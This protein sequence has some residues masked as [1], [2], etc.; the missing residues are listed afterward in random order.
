[1]YDLIIIGGGP[2]GYTAALESVK[3]NKKVLIIEK[4]D[5]GGVCLNRGCIPTKSL[6]NSGKL[7]KKSKASSE[8]G[9]DYSDISFNFKNAV[10]WKDKSVEELR[11]SL[12]NL[13]KQRGIDVIKGLASVINRNEVKVHDVIYKT[14]FILIATGSKPIIPKI[15]G[16]D[17]EYVL[18]SN[19]ILDLKEKPKSITI[20]GGGVIGV[21]FASFFNSI[22]VK[23]NLIELQKSILPTMDIRLGKVLKK[24]LKVNY[25]LN[26]E[27]KSIEKNCVIFIQ[28]GEEGC[29]TSDLILIAVGRKP[30]TSFVNSLGLGLDGYIEVDKYM[31]TSIK[32]IYAVGD[33]TAKTFLAHGATK[34]AEIAVFNMFFSRTTLRE[35][36]FKIIP[37][38]IYSEPEVASIGLTSNEAKSLEL[39]II[40]SSYYL[41]N[42]G[43]YLVE[44]GDENGICI[45]IADFTSRVILGVHIIGTSA[46]EII[47][48]GTIAIQEKFTL[49]KFSELIFPHPTLSET[50]KETIFFNN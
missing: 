15:T 31:Q 8:L 36:D 23:V 11:S 48:L 39:K 3:L 42:N 43:R 29:I 12:E 24:S 4:K 40:K 33:C 16:I 22:E 46:S 44:N 14:H 47:S 50:I 38:V 1:M 19:D 13:I 41:K 25:Y 26:T 10:S 6:L 35:M 17:S 5:I 7:Y 20:I 28:N 2:G 18:T 30:N 34:M 9:I 37:S 49:E 45:V 32:N 21:E 27:V